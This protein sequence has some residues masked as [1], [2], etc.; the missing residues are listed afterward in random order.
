MSN[1]IAATSLHK[2]K[3]SPKKIIARCPTNESLR[4]TRA[5]SCIA[6]GLSLMGGTG[7]CMENLYFETSDKPHL[8]VYPFAIHRIQVTGE[9]PL[10]RT[11]GGS[12]S[13]EPAAPRS[14]QGISGNM[15]KSSR[16]RAASAF[17]VRRKR[18]DHSEAT[19]RCYGRIFKHW[20]RGVMA[21]GR[22]VLKVY[23]EM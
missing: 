8:H 14:F 20:F 12:E 2:L 23:D 6:L 21:N 13:G 9:H 16:V 15:C 7:S 22:D 1:W 17:L 10:T 18:P 19:G 3:S 11:E 5:F 4:G